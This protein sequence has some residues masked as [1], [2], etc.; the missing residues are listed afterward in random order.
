MARMIDREETMRRVAAAFPSEEELAGVEAVAPENLDDADLILMYGSL[1]F[2]R[3][4]RVLDLSVY[5]A[6]IMRRAA[7]YMREMLKRENLL[8][9]KEE[10][11]HED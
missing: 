11:D 8:V 7:V 2:A 1:L 6:E 4:D 9:T 10:A 5:E 3:R